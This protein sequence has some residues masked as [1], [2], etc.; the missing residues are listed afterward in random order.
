MQHSCFGMAQKSTRSGPELGPFLGLEA[1]ADR[2]KL[3]PESAN[4]RTCQVR[5]LSL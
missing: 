2:T 3:S 5:I 1:P 4:I